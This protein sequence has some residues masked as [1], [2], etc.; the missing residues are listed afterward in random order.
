M[1]VA[2][3]LLF[4]P[5]VLFLVI[6]MPL[7]LIFHYTTIWKRDRR[8]QNLENSSHADLHAQADMMEDRLDAIEK[9]LDVDTPDWRSRT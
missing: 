3:E 7:W 4:V 9:L 1:D 2:S 5:T 8:Q 6:V